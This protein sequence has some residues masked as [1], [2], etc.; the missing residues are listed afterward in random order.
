MQVP[1]FCCKVEEERSQF[2]INIALV[3]KR[4]AYTRGEML[5]K[6]S[7]KSD[8]MY[9]VAQGVI[10]AK[11]SI[12]RSGDF[13]GEDMIMQHGLR[14]Y[15]ATA[16]TFVDTQTLSRNMLFE[17]LER[18]D[19]PETE[20]LIHIAALRLAIKKYLKQLV[21]AIKSAKMMDTKRK[22]MTDEEIAQW[23]EDMRRRSQQKTERVVAAGGGRAEEG[24]EKGEEESLIDI[25]ADPVRSVLQA[26]KQKKDANLNIMA[27]KLEHMSASIKLLQAAINATG[28]SIN[29]LRGDFSKHLGIG[30]GG[31][32]SIRRIP[33]IADDDEW[34]P[35]T[36]PSNN[37]DDVQQIDIMG[38]LKAAT[39]RKGN[40]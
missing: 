32:S 18:G 5:F 4:R 38:D 8:L 15:R 19:F 40:Q 1:F 31:S 12:L 33:T 27:K 2:I 30:S 25:G 36:P 10:G 6:T 35:A 28:E 3:L 22:K 21:T 11:G 13:V 26:N 34:R 9:I 24:E 20:K 7:E 29:E 14:T 39:R 16:M 17:V 37:L 23:K